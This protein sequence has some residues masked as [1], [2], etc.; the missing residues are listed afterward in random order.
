MVVIA[1]DG[2]DPDPPH[3]VQEALVDRCGKIDSLDPGIV[4]AIVLR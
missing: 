3:R 1:D 2:P 4:G